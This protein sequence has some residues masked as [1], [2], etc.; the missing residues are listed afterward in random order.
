MD[1]K[2]VNEFGT[3]GDM[4]EQPSQQ[5]GTAQAIEGDSPEAGP[6][7]GGGSQEEE[8]ETDAPPKTEQEKKED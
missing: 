1:S 5:N 3:S 7:A 8:K 2:R 6:L 4:F